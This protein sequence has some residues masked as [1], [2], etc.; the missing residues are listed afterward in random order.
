MGHVPILLRGKV[1]VQTEINIYAIAYNFKR[2]L[3]VAS[4][5]DL[6]KMFRPIQPKIS[7]G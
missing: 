6:E 4:F 2:M 1:K 5:E 3:N 7:L